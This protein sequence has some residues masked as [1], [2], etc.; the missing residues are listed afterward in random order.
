MYPISALIEFGCDLSAVTTLTCVICYYIAA[1]YMFMAFAEDIKQAM[2]DL[3]QIR[4]TKADPK[5][6]KEKMS[7]II[8]L[9][10]NAKQLSLSSI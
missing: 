9:H 8:R 5:L 4:R 3:N 10:S 7:E 6:F 2:N 1:C